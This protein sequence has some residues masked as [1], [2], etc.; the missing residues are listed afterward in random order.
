[1]QMPN[2]APSIDDLYPPETS[3]ALP[4]SS[5]GVPT[6]DELFGPSQ[7]SNS[8]RG[9]EH[10]A[11]Y[12][13]Q[14]VADK[15]SRVLKTIN[16]GSGYSGPINDMDAENPLTTISNAANKA[17]EWLSGK[18][19]EAGLP[20]WA[21]ASYGMAHAML[22]NPLTTM[23]QMSS[24]IPVAPGAQE[25]AQDMGRRALGVN[26]GMIKKMPGGVEAAN[27]KA[28]IMMDNSVPSF[29][30]GAEGNL[31]LAEKAAEDSG[32]VLGVIAK[33]A[34]SNVVDTNDIASKIIDELAP[35]NV[36]IKGAYIAHEKLANDVM[37][38]ITA[39][40]NGPISF[41]EAARLKKTLQTEAG[42]NWNNAPLR[43][44][45]YQ[46]AYMIVGDEMEQGLE[47]LS[48]TGA[49][50]K[51]LLPLYQKQKQIYG[52]SKMAITGLRDKAAAEAANNI[53][54]L[55][56]MVA[57]AGALAAGNVSHGLATL[58][59]WEAA[60]RYGAG[61]VARSMNAVSKAAIPGAIVNPAIAIGEGASN[62]GDGS[63]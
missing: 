46:K 1:M 29:F 63:Q 30:S 38:T 22:L 14:N 34:G 7:D 58:G 43:A 50:P 9:S 52:A 20:D 48:Q 5:S 23:D 42:A 21:S 17:G 28:Q 8:Q 60:R 55:P 36:Q 32:R 39:H 41:E 44:A 18:A 12:K 27:A 59:F 37:D 47:R 25:V 57:G 6:M 53:W 56:G 13:L 19:G 35:Q 15:I 54:S 33:R 40:G 3:S 10:P 49:I 11:N 61:A 2:S 24:D 31:N 51:D 26:K 4:P 45:A 62:A 16:M